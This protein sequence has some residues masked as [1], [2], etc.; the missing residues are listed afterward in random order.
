MQAGGNLMLDVRNLAIPFAFYL[1]SI[2]LSKKRSSSTAKKTKSPKKSQKGGGCGCNSN[3][4]LLGGA[5][6][7]PLHP[8][9]MME[10]AAP[11]PIIGGNTSRLAKLVGGMNSTLNNILKATSNI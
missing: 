2:G 9:G 4:A 6:A 5:A 11:A 3:K 1:A 8:G 10:L 7:S